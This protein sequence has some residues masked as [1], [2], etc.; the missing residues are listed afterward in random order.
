MAWQAISIWFLISIE[1][2]L[3]T[4]WSSFFLPRFFPTLLVSYLPPISGW[5]WLIWDSFRIFLSSTCWGRNGFLWSESLIS[6][7]SLILQGML[8]GLEVS[9]SAITMNYPLRTSAGWQFSFASENGRGL[10]SLISSYFK[11][12]QQL[13]Y[14][15]G[16]IWRS[17]KDI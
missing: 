17:F 13:N 11:L 14:M 16:L 8:D 9:D 6:W 12:C 15:Y 1:V 5:I 4:N 7:I 2:N 3:W 10:V